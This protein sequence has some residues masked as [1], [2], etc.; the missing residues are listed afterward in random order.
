MPL[1]ETERLIA[2]K[3][4][5][6]DVPVLTAMLSDPEVMKFSVLEFVTKKLP[7]NSL[8]GA[9]SVTPLMG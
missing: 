6:Q 5:H 4:S 7:E 9:L 8:I 3:L 2:R 1:F